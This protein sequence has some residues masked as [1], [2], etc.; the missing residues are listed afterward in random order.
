MRPEAI[1]NRV[2]LSNESRAAV[3]RFVAEDGAVDSLLPAVVDELAPHEA[4][5]TS[6]TAKHD[7][8]AGA[9][10]QFS[11]SAVCVSVRRVVSFIEFQAVFVAIFGEP[12]EG[13]L[14]AGST[15][16]SDYPIFLSAAF[17]LAVPHARLRA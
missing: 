3:R 16:Y 1:S 15:R 6:L 13:F 10:E 12:P 8:L 4:S 2:R 14:H 7:F 11:L 5:V 9:D 17:S